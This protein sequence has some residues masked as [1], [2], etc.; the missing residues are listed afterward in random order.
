MAYAHARCSRLKRSN[1]PFGLVKTND[2]IRRRCFIC[3]QLRDTPA[4]T[5]ETNNTDYVCGRIKIYLTY[6]LRNTQIARE[7]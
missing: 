3:I 1:N 6:R 4:W 5:T 2:R 7:L